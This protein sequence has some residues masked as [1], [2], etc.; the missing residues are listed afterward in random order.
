MSA[1]K[2]SGITVKLKGK[3]YRLLFT[4][5]ALDEVQTKFGGYDK[6]NEAFNQKNPGWIKDTIWLLT[7]LINEGLREEGEE[8]T[9]FTEERISHIIHM[10]NLAEVQRAI[11]AS[12][13][14]GTAGDEESSRDTETEDDEEAGEMKAVQES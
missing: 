11:F 1:I 8:T 14:A 13:A 7:L 3:E 4:L 12:F 9:L 5:Y 10:G 2:D 6:M